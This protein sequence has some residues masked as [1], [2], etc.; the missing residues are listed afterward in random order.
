MTVQAAGQN[1]GG[2]CLSAPPGSAEKI[3]VVDAVG[4]KSLHEWLSD[5]RL[6]NELTKSLRS[7]STIERGGHDSSLPRALP[8][9]GLKRDFTTITVGLNRVPGSIILRISPVLPQ[10]PMGLHQE[11]S[12][13]LRLQVSKRT[14]ERFGLTYSGKS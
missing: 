14:R 6:A 13:T 5:L 4:R 8:I 12:R 9:R 7:I 3:R 11:K 2:S 10:I 1:S